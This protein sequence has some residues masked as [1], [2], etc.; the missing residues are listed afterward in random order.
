MTW[1]LPILAGRALYGSISLV[2]RTSAESSFRRR[3]AS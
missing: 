3:S 2:V 1:H